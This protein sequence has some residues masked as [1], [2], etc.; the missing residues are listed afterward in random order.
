M[1]K[2]C[3][4]LSDNVFGRGFDSRRLH[5]RWKKQQCN[6]NNENMLDACFQ[7]NRKDGLKRKLKESAALQRTK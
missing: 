3:R 5:Q 6:H 4:Y 1:E 7:R 2:A